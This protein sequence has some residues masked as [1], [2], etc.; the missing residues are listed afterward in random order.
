MNIKLKKI[1]M[2][3]ISSF[4]IVGL[5]TGCGCSKKDD[6]VDTQIRENKNSNI[7]KPQIIDNL[8]F[9]NTSIVFDPISGAYGN[10][11]FTT[12]VTN[13][14]NEDVSI[15]HI[16]VKVLDDDGNEIITLSGLILDPIPAGDS[17]SFSSFCGLDLTDA[18][19]IEFS[20]I[21]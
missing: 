14:G 4:L 7:S 9:E 11:K 10:T 6:G 13:I 20:V 21:Y 8:K 5:L 19:N 3:G 2:V 15:E 1:I 17:R 18:K 12:T 16:D